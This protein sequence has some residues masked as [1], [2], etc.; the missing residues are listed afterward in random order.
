L[1]FFV[2]VFFKCCFKIFTKTSFLE[3][4]VD[5]FKEV[6]VNRGYVFY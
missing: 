4:I 6:H 3:T 2:H 5:L 1:C